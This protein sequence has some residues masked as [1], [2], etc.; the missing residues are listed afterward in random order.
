M[1]S[2][3]NILANDSC[4]GSGPYDVNDRSGRGAD[5]DGVPEEKLP[6][7]WERSTPTTARKTGP[8]WRRVKTLSSPSSRPDKNST[9]GKAGFRVGQRSANPAPHPAGSAALEAT[10][11]CYKLGCYNKGD[12]DDHTNA[13]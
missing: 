6:E 5:P 2:G 9:R 10:L 4:Q 1:R 8:T 12:R 11:R 3:A 7:A 13:R